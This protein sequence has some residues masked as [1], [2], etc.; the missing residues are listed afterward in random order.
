MVYKRLIGVIAV[1]NAWAVQSF[2]YKRTLPLGRPEMLAENLDRWGVDEIV[3]LDFG[4]SRQG[5]GPDFK[6]LNRLTALGLGTPLA[7]GGGICSVDDA[8]AVIQTGVERICIDSLLHTVPKT[9]C[10]LAAHIGGQAIIGALPVKRANEQGLA[11]YNHRSGVISDLDTEI[12]GLFSEQYISEALLID[13]RH[14]GIENSFDASI[15]SLFSEYINSV[16]LLLY[17]GISEFSQVETYLEY[18]NVVGVCIGN[19]LNYKEHA[20]QQFKEQKNV[21]R[22]CRPAFYKEDYL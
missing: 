8:V 6:L 21:S 17:G 11:W 2:G 7:Y 3:I 15:P 16:P 19:F 10:D 22:F 12:I 14:E 1:E 4:R 5:L 9:V 20:I 18:E 13:Y